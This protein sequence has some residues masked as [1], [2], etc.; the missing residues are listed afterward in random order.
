[1]VAGSLRQHLPDVTNRTGLC[2][3]NAA[4]ELGYEIRADPGV[5]RNTHRIEVEADAARFSMTIESVPSAEN[6]RTGRLTPL[7]VIATLRGLVSTLRV[8]TRAGR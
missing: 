6:P 5:S 4:G 2:Q 1:M 3:S 8:G 7:S